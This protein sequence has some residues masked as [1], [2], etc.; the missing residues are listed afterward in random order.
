MRT[1]CTSSLVNGRVGTCCNLTVKRRIYPRM[2]ES[3]T[4]LEHPGVVR[5]L[6]VFFDIRRHRYR[7]R[8]VTFHLDVRFPFCFPSSRRTPH[9]ARCKR[10]SL[11]ISRPW[12]FPS[13]RLSRG[14]RLSFHFS[15]RAV[16]LGQACDARGVRRFLPSIAVHAPSRPVSQPVRPG[17]P[18]LCSLGLEDSRA[19][20]LPGVV[21][22][23]TSHISA[24]SVL[25]KGSSRP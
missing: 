6:L 5:S 19:L 22:M 24:S 4:P 18:G 1:T 11:A 23:P 21:T 13:L 17:H 8:L 20:D 7:T 9:I 16:Y 3:M 15:C 10:V 14:P 12:Q 25:A 2:A